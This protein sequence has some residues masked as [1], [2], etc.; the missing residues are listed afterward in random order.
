VLIQELKKI[1]EVKEIRLNAPKI[2]DDIKVL[3][4]IHPRDLPEE[5]EYAIDQYVLRGGKLIAFVDPYAYFDQQPDLQNPFG[6]NQAG[7]STFY[8][9]FKAWGID[10]DM[11]KVIADLTF[12]SG[13]GPRLLPTLLALTTQA[14]NLDDVVTSQVGT[15]LIPFG[16]AFKGKPAEGLTQTV[17]A[18]TSKNSMPV[19]LIIAT[20]SGEPSTR[21]FQPSGEEM[22]LAIRLTGKFH[23]AFPEGKPRPFMPPRAD[24]KKGQDEKKKA[25]DKTEPQLRQS[26]DEN[27][28]V[29]VADVDLLSDGAAVEIQDVFGQRVVVPRNG[30]LA[31]ALGLVEQLS[32]DSAL[33][34]LRSRAS[35]SRP[36][37]VLREMEAQAQQQYLGKIK[38]LE[39]SLN[40]TQE[41]LQ[42]LQK[43]K[44]GVTS[45]ILTAEQQAE[46]D[47]FRK[48]AAEARLALKQLRK[49]LRV[50]TD[51]L[52]F[53]TKVVNIGLV[54]LL[55]ALAGLA[56]ALARR[57]RLNPA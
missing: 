7:Q 13:A 53:W 17:L 49:N 1:F 31:L 34:S 43:S 22:P 28:V 55:V 26:K 4:V 32:G 6:G 19:D 11:G 35:F 52:E 9:L 2:D 14:L 57:R 50:E 42:K 33:I 36:L 29:L 44:A 39:D 38:E 23:T 21:G 27:S 54:P 18:R 48:K 46:L 40:Q 37:T 45:S 8:N 51:T 30:N 25:E 5:T 15:L 12:A 24:P 47:N 41:N 16:G 3:L 20:L 56:L 10:V